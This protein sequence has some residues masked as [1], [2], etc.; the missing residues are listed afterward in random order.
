MAPDRGTQ[1]PTNLRAS[2]LAS[3]FGNSF[4]DH[5]NLGTFCRGLFKRARSFCASSTA[6]SVG[7]KMK[8][9]IGN[10]PWSVTDM[11][12]LD[13]FK[14]FGDVVSAQVVMDRD[15]GRSR[16]FGF[17]EMAAHHASQAIAKLNGSTVESRLLRVN[18]AQS[19]ARAF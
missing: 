17:V 9:Y 2:P 10:L 6:Y 12:L 11:D 15:S 1:F 18:E 4:L 7:E 5:K 3:L 13:L 8:V 14:P 19:K 16:G